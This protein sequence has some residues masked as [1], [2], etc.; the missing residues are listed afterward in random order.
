[1]NIIWTKPGCPFCDMAKTFLNQRNISYEE[2]NI[3]NGWTREQLLEAV[4]T[5]KTVPQIFINGKYIGTYENLK[6]SYYVQKKLEA[7]D[8][9]HHL[10]L[11]IATPKNI[12]EI[13]CGLGALTQELIDRGHSVLACDNKYYKTSND[14]QEQ[15]DAFDVSRKHFYYKIPNEEHTSENIKMFEELKSYSESKYD[16]ILWQGNCLYQNKEVTLECTQT[17]IR[18][19]VNMLDSDGVFVMGYNPANG[20]T[21]ET[22]FE[23]TE[24]YQWLKPWL[25]DY[26]N[27]CMGYYTWAIKRSDLQ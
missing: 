14:Y 27:K 17:L 12:L 11:D 13:G 4:P 15:L 19:I 25:T 23:S 10:K 6:N 16:Y 18:N 9:I 8:T 20:N 5:A 2:R 22:E 24:S 3:G 1:M 7:K 26:Y 21:R